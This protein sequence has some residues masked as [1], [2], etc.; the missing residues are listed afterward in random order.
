MVD[1][2]TCE[3][4]AQSAANTL[5]PNFNRIIGVFINNAVLVA[6]NAFI[7]LANALKMALCLFGFLIPMVG[8]AHLSKLADIN[9]V[10]SNCRGRR[11]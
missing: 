7:L 3:Q 1:E 5:P 8:R 10:A 6:Q 11:H 4:E 9:E 2:V